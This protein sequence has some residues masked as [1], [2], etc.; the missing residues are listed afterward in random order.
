MKRSS[1]A[2]TVRVAACGWPRCTCSVSEESPG[3]RGLSDWVRCCWDARRAAA[4]SCGGCCAALSACA[5]EEL[6]RH[7]RERKGGQT[8][9]PIAV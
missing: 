3:G 8:V 2:S 7:A 1:S 6:C 5:C 9:G 4:P